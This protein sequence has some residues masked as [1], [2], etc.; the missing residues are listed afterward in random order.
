MTNPRTTR[1]PETRVEDEGGAAAGIRWFLTVLAWFLLIPPWG[2]IVYFYAVKIV[3]E[4]ERGVIFRMGRL[5]GAK[6]PGLFLILPIVDRMV[7]M[8]LRTVTMD[9]PSQECIT[10]D[11]VTVKVNAVIYF[12]VVN[13]EDAVV[14]V[15]DHFRATS[16][17]AQTT[18]RSVIGQSDLDELLSEREHINERL[19]KIIDEQ[20]EPWG[21]KVSTVEV[22]DVELPQS[23]QRAI[24]RQ[25]EAERERRA[26]V[27]NADGEL[28]A[29]ERLAEAGRIMSE[30]PATLQL[31]FLQTLSEVAT[32]KNSTIVFPVPVDLINLLTANLRRSDGA[33][34]G[35]RP[36]VRV[37]PNGASTPPASEG[38]GP[39]GAITAPASEPPEPPT[40]E[41][42]VS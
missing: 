29:S 18:L 34:D 20:T 28:Q 2:F 1:P 5:V 10:R 36:R 7:K 9:V 27:I 33:N 26:K 23:M 38:G 15:L 42:T 32:E 19:Q 8:D 11:N 13:P 41:G 22:K 40:R 6:G 24:A 35:P 21:V 37:G 12:R 25:A 14:R 4:Y 17:I 16:Q 31:R 3:S 30:Q 39:A